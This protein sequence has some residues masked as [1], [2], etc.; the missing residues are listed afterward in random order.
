MRLSYFLII[1]FIVE[2]FLFR[3]YVLTDITPFY[4]ANFDQ[5]SFLMM[6]YGAMDRIQHH[7]VWQGLLESPALPTGVLFPLQV[8]LFFV[9]FG[10]SRFNGLLINFIYF[11]A[12]QFF[13]T[14]TVKKISGSHFVALIALGLLLAV[15]V[16]FMVPGGITD[17]RMDFI[18]FCLYGMAITAM[19]RS[20]VFKILI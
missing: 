17:L 2:Y 11:I 7:G 3:H 16:P 1:T 8:I 13:F 20:D 14:H 6:I 10:V 19:V 9:V 4:P 12:L 5:Q 15:N 18:A